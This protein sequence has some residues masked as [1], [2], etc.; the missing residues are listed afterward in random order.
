MCVGRWLHKCAILQAL[1]KKVYISFKETYSPVSILLEIWK[2]S[3]KV[4]S[5]QANGD[6][7]SISKHNIAS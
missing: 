2:I 1:L 7:E 6:S 5:E 3:Q 4:I